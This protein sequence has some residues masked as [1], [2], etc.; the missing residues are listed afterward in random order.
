MTRRDSRSR[1]RLT[2]RRLH[3][4]VRRELH[5]RS[6]REAA[7]DLTRLVA[8]RGW[9]GLVERTGLT[10]QRHRAPAPPPIV[11]ASSLDERV[12]T[13][14]WNVAVDPYFDLS[15]AELEANAAVVSRF[16]ERPPHI[17]SATWF[18][19]RFEHALFGGVYTIL[20]L[21][22]W[23]TANHGV[24]H[25]LVIFDG[26]EAT[27]P[28]IRGMVRDVFPN[29]ADIDIALP[30]PMRPLPVDELPRT[31]IAV[32]S[33]WSSAYAL[34]RFNPTSAKFYMVQD[35]EP[36]FYPAG[37]IFALAEATY[38]LGF[39]GL[40]NTPG[41]AEVYAAYGNPTT[42]FV[43]AV[44]FTVPEVAKPSA[45]GGPVQVVLYG[46]PSTDRNGFELIAAACHQIKSRYGDSV[47]IVSAGEDFEPAAFLLD[48]VI[49]N[50]GLLRDLD[51]VR[52][53]YAASD[54]GVCF[55]FSKHPSYQ[56]FEYLAARVVPVCNTNA[57]TGWLLRDGENCLIT[58]PFPSGVAEAV[59]RLIE[60]P[61]LRLKLAA[62][63]HEEV[64]GTTW[65]SEL[66]RTWRFM[67]N[68][69]LEAP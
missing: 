59:G 22:S 27:D 23:M 9:R 58:E 16:E 47:R 67:T 35:F 15:P 56:P 66:G 37:T 52:Q 20:R 48:G 3:D 25:R 68:Q 49:E 53:L 12:G 69:P 38:R 40:V 31:D 65:E 64:T 44:D 21:M 51:S 2:V 26:H 39:A 10:I 18:L 6:W 30:P 61:E 54:I 62:A 19:P 57:A 14:P 11:A 46:R 32:C 5:G 1:S 43:P 4:R 42:A 7:S 13:Y 55:M 41:L 8:A 60:D 28:A 45:E 34:A 17:S 36:S 29:L 33:L 50:A 63:G 24:E